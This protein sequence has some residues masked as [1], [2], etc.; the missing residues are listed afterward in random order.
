MSQDL[1]LRLVVLMP[2]RDDWQSAAEL[3]RRIDRAVSS[4]AHIGDHPSRRR[5]SAEGCNVPSALTIPFGF[6]P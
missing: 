5:F 1:P 6:R 2:V 3:I 4:N